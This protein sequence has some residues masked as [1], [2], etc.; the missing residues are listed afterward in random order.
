MGKGIPTELERTRGMLKIQQQVS[1][2]WELGSLAS[3]S[4]ISHIKR[5]AVLL[6]SHLPHSAPSENNDNNK[7][8]DKTFLWKKKRQLCICHMQR[9]STPDPNCSL[10]EGSAFCLS[11]PWAWT[12]GSGARLMPGERERVR[13]WWKSQCTSKPEAGSCLDWGKALNW[14]HI[15]TSDDYADLDSPWFLFF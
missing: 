10:I 4:G 9:A 3:P 6:S 12:G 8:H 7:T 1:K 11:S 5:T 14:M 2:S 15:W 13:A